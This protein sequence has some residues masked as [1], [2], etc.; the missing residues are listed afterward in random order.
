MEDKRKIL[1]VRNFDLDLHDKKVL[2]RIHKEICKIYDPKYRMKYHP[3]NC[4]INS[5]HY[6]LKWDRSFLLSE[7]IINIKDMKKIISSLGFKTS[8]KTI[9]HPLQQNSIIT[10]N[11]YEELCSKCSGSGVFSEYV[12][13]YDYSRFIGC[14]KCK[15]QGRINWI[16]KIKGTK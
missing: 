6:L 12:K 10:L 4:L 13:K 9:Y 2:G 3:N 16:D 5:F 7:Y 11:D 15:G 14:K 1:V 8:L